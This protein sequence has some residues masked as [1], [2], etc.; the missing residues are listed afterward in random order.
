MNF[1][2]ASTMRPDRCHAIVIGAWERNGL[3]TGLRAGLERI[4]SL[5]FVS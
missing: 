2:T 5:R 3:H 4:V 1:L